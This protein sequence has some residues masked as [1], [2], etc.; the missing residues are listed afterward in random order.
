VRTLPLA[1]DVP[2]LC[3]DKVERFFVIFVFF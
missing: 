1:N 3:W 2:V